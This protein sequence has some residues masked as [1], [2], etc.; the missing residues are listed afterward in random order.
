[1]YLPQE[2]F[3]MS[4]SHHPRASSERPSVKPDRKPPW[5]ELERD[6]KDEG[7]RTDALNQSN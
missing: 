1:M 3:Q 6:E 2:A 7:S 5:G 4:H